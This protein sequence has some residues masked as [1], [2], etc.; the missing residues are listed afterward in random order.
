M[1][2]LI[3]KR[4]QKNKKLSTLYVL[5]WSKQ[6]LQGIGY[7]HRNGIL[8]R[9]LKPS[10]IFLDGCSVVIGDLGLAKSTGESKSST[11]FHGTLPYSSPEVI[12]KEP[13]SIK[14]DI[15]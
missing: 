12:S 8:H 14:A 9:D 6:I 2:Q 11:N 5:C 7:L 3:K 4:K 1:D 13:Y 15:W 10:N